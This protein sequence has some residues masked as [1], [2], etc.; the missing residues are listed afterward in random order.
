MFLYFY[1]IGSFFI[2]LVNLNITY[3]N[4][5]N[6]AIIKAYSMKLEKSDSFFIGSSIYSI[7][8]TSWLKGYLLITIYLVLLVII[9][10]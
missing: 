10:F 3:I 8:D 2:V 1:F 5:S 9:I 6:I 7:I 4:R